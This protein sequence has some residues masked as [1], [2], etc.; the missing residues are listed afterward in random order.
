MCFHRLQGIEKLVAIVCFKDFC[1]SSS[2][3][4]ACIQIAIFF[5][6]TTLGRMIERGQKE[7]IKQ[8]KKISKE[9]HNF[10]D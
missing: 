7:N 10:N 2:Y 4:L 5:F 9:N 6:F 8:E 1:S 3:L